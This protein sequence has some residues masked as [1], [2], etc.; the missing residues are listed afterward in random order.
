MAAADLAD[1]EGWLGLNLSRVA[2]EVD[3]HVTSLYSHVDGIEDLRREVTMLAMEE[4]GSA[5]WQAALGRSGEDALLSLAT[6]Y[7][8]YAVE[9]PGRTEAMATY[10]DVEDPDSRE[11]SRHVAEPFNATFRSFGLDE[12]QVVHAYRIVLATLRGFAISEAAG[13]YGSRENVDDTFRQIMLLFVRALC[14]GD[15]PEA[16]PAVTAASA[17]ER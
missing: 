10:Q 9:H 1:R 16:Q 14:S 15:W 13:R 5:L 17:G 11:L 6:V 2:K 7:R 12:H 3:R 4:L 8:Q